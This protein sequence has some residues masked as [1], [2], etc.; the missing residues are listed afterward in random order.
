V[1]CHCCSGR[2]KKSGFFGVQRIQRYC[3]TRCGKT[4][5]AIPNRPFDDHRIPQDKAIQIVHLLVEGVGIRAIERLTGISKP[6]ILALLQTVSAKCER[7]LERKLT[8]VSPE[9]VQVDEIWTY[10]GCKQVNTVPEDLKRGD[11]YL[12]LGIDRYTKLIL[13]H[14]VGK[15]DTDNAFVFMAQLKQ[16]V[17]THFQLTTDGF[18]SYFY[19]A[20]QLLSCSRYAWQD[21]GDGR[22]FGC[23]TLVNRRTVTTS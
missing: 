1:Q 12:F 5:S 8:G 17:P 19:R 4:F 14:H 13:A 2:C 22:E 7:L 15:R 23:C 21:P 9:F 10:S 11:Q 3:C 18:T 20:F 16:R 6:T